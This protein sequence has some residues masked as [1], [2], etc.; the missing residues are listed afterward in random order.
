M[1]R[2]W[3]TARAVPNDNAVGGWTVELDSKP[4]RVPGGAKLS[5]PSERLAQ[6]VAAE[7]QE[8]GG[9]VGGKMTYDDLPLTR[10]AGTAQERVSVARAAVV[11]E[12]A[13]Y[14]ESDLLCYRAEH[15]A[16]LVSAQQEQWQPWL[17]WVARETGAR[18]LVTSSISHIPQPDDAL[19]TLA[20]QIAVHDSYRLAALGVLVPSFGS[21][22]LGL[23]VARGALAAAEAHEIAT[24]DERHQA[25][26]WGWDSEAE[27]RMAKIADDVAVAGRFLDLCA[28]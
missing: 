4:V 6:A 20:A 11:E 27:T 26:L 15:P 9:A 22:V 8:A 18:L 14:A 21:V 28:G 24:L 2:F 12:I 10:L 16:A 1:K 7:W 17:D 25:S 23:A 3:E 13:R 19:A 5:L